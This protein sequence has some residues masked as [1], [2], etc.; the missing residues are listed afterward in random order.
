[1]KASCNLLIDTNVIIDYAVPTRPE[2]EVAA[3]LFNQA[4]SDE[5]VELVVLISS[6][7]DVYYVMCRNYSKEPEART[8]L[9]RMT[10]TYFTVADLLAAYGPMALASNEPDFE[11]GLVRAAAESLGVKAIVTRDQA[12][13]QN[14]YLKAF[15]PEQATAFV[16]SLHG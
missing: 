7:K 4:V 6:L 13:F 1:M 8:A 16:R 9:K 10:E 3:E 12:A 2:H 14:S 5:T 15:T 11:D